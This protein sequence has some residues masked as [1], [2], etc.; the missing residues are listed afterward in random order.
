MLQARITDE[1][2]VNTVS[3]FVVANDAEP[4]LSRS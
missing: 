1:L 2:I 3:A 4:L